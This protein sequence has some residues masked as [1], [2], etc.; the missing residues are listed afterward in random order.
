MGEE[1]REK[2]G[3]IQCIRNGKIDKEELERRAEDALQKQ[4]QAFRQRR[5][6]EGILYMGINGVYFKLLQECRDD[7]KS[8]EEIIEEEKEEMMEWAKK[9]IHEQEKEE[10]GGD[11]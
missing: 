10:E 3:E 11:E 2:F 8:E 5:Y 1:K 6:L 9:R 4:F 7:E